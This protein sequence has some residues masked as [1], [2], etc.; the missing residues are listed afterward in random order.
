[1]SSSSNST[2]SSNPTGVGSNPERNYHNLFKTDS[3][4]DSWS[5]TGY[6]YINPFMHKL[7]IDDSFD[8]AKVS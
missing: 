3:Q 8:I 7:V 1:M 5:S 4:D 2:I 6:S